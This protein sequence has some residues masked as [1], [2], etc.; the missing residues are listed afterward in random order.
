M[1]NFYPKKSL[2]STKHYY[3]QYLFTFYVHWAAGADDVRRL[4]G[5]QWPHKIAARLHQHVQNSDIWKT[6]DIK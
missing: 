3:D 2:K 1:T 5:I 4:C 6:R